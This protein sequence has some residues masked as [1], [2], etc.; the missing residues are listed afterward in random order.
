MTLEANR[1]PTPPAKEPNEPLYGQPR[2]YEWWCRVRDVLLVRVT[3][4]PEYGYAYH[5]P[6]IPQCVRERDSHP[7][8]EWEEKVQ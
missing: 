6:E 8:C 4:V 7:D 2:T 1:Q 5:W 3:T